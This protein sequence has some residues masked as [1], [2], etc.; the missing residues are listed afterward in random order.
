MNSTVKNFWFFFVM[1]LAVNNFRNFFSMKL[2]VKNSTFFREIRKK[3]F[4]TQKGVTGGKL[5]T[6]S[7]KIRFF[8]VF[9][10]I[11]YYVSGWK[12][13]NH[14]NILQIPKIIT[15]TIYLTL[16][17]KLRTKFKKNI[18]ASFLGQKSA[19]F[20]IVS[21]LLFLLSMKEKMLWFY[22]E[23]FE[24]DSFWWR[25]CA[26]DVRKWKKVTLNKHV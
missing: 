21:Y 11:S 2:T 9:V 20:E 1:N 12:L 25:L 4:V 6:F 5:N 17:L 8:A 15:K 19:N 7:R 23:R 13:V 10:F 26:V 18:A 22:L 14:Q 16:W 3:H 24:K